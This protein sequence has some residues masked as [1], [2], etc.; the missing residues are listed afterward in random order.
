MKLYFDNRDGK[1]DYIDEFSFKYTSTTTLIHK[2]QPKFE[3][4]KLAKACERIGSNPNH[5]KY[6]KYKGMKAWQILKMWDKDAKDGCAIGNTHHDKLEDEINLS[7]CKLKPPQ[8]LTDHGI[9]LF[10][11]EDVI[12]NPDFGIIDLKKLDASDIKIEYPQIYDLLVTLINKGYRIYAELGLFDFDYKVSGLGDIIP[13]HLENKHFFVLDWKT[14]KIPI[15]KTSGYYEKDNQRNV[16]LDKFVASDEKLLAPLGH[17]PNA[18][19][20]IYA[21]QL[22]IYQRMIEQ[23]GFT[24]GGRLIIHIRRE[25][26]STKDAIELNDMRLENKHVINFVPIEDLQIEVEHMFKHKRESEL[27]SK[28]NQSN[29]FDSVF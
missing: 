7:M 19:Y 6:E 3:S 26:Y 29:L 27:L 20:Y 17:L 9:Q 1:H 23:K 10:T 18:N 4:D 15:I 22:N 24:C 25:L 21:L 13:I 8:R 14:N 16:L 28:G 2:Y 5:P 11:L 12:A